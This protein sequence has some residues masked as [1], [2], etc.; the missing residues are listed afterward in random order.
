M[1][2]E[3]RAYLYSLNLYLKTNRKVNEEIRLSKKYYVGQ[4]LNFRRK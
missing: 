4:N 2:E 1:K 3:I